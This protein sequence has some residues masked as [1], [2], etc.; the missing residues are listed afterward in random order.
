MAC[1]LERCRKPAA[2]TGASGRG[3][4]VA[5]DI[6]G[7][8]DQCIR[9]VGGPTVISLERLDVIGRDFF[10]PDNH[11]RASFGR[12]VHKHLQELE[13]LGATPDTDLAADGDAHTNPL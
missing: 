4:V 7:P 6:L 3:L 12:L 13:L 1:C 11:L 2:D 9:R 5:G 8:P 10:A